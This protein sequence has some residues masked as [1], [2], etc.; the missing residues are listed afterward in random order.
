MERNVERGVPVRLKVRAHV[1]CDRRERDRAAGSDFEC[2]SFSSGLLTESGRSVTR[3]K[4]RLGSRLARYRTSRS[5]TNS[6]TCFSLR[7]NDGTATMVVQ[8]GGMPLLKSSLCR[9]LGSKKEV[10]ALLTNSTATCMAGNSKTMMANASDAKPEVCE[11][12]GKSTTAIRKIAK[13]FMPVM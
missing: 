1:R 11:R 13:R 9:G 3:A 10:T 12:T 5:L 8:V 2:V 6:C 4:C 7:S